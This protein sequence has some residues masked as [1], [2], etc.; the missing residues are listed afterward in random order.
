MVIRIY[1]LFCVFGNF[2]YSQTLYLKLTPS[3]G[4][5][6]GTYQTKVL[7][8]NKPSNLTEIKSSRLGNVNLAVIYYG[9]D[10]SLLKY[11]NLIF[12]FSISTTG[13]KDGAG[14]LYLT[15]SNII[16]TTPNILRNRALYFM[17]NTAYVSRNLGVNCAYTINQKS[18]LEVGLNYQKSI[19]QY[20]EGGGSSG[21][22]MVMED[23]YYFYYQINDGSYEGKRSL[24]LK[25]EYSRAFL[26]K[27]GKNVCNLNFSYMQ[28]FQKMAHSITT[29]E[30]YPLGYKMIIESFSRGSSFSLTVTKP[31]NIYTKSKKTV[32]EN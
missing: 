28:G 23:G 3:S 1:I 32:N 24:A 18:Q 11:K 17:D 30:Q 8:N 29:F 13:I 5:N 25:L 27:R 10:L 16:E 22:V 2:F 26:S 21:D 7:E 14:A 19:S 4:V 15:T 20:P 31:I 9:L 12:G 6:F